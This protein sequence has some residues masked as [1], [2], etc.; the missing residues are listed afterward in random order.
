M[1]KFYFLF[2]FLALVPWVRPQDD[3]PQRFSLNLDLTGH[4]AFASGG[5]A[6]SPGVGASAFAEWRPM[7]AL[8]F[9]SGFSFFYHPD[10]PSWSLAS[11]DMGGRLYPLGATP[12]GEWYCQ[13][14]AGLDVVTASLKDK[15]P[16]S[17]HGTAGLGYRFFSGARNALDLGVQY[18]LFSPLHDPLQAVGVKVGWVF[19][20]GPPP[21]GAEPASPQKVQAPPASASVQPTPIPEK[22][23]EKKKERQAQKGPQGRAHRHPRSQWAPHLSMG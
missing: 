3:P 6:F 22:R 11:W 12:A 16:G 17:F 10:N 13:G 2:F 7:D 20:F 1:K 23:V 19:L 5:P 9:G 4:G 14:T 8:S 21:T 18:E 15:W